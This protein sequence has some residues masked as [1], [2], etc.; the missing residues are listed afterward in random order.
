MESISTRKALSEVCGRLS[1]SGNTRINDVDLHG[2]GRKEEIVT[3]EM[4]EKTKKCF[5]R[6]CFSL[7]RATK[8]PN[9]DGVGAKNVDGHV[10]RLLMK[11][12]VI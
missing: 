10:G 11:M 9:S 4:N 3:N 12:T 7:Q 2:K 6:V 8:A 5:L 1:E